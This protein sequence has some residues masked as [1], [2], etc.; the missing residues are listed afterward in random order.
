MVGYAVRS[1]YP[2]LTL[3]DCGESSGGM[4]SF[5]RADLSAANQRPPIAIWTHLSL[6]YAAL[7]PGG[8]L[9]NLDDTSYLDHTLIPAAYHRDLVI[10]LFP[11]H[12]CW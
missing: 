10:S 2:A 3:L 6:Q 7:G 8:N 1:C 11:A 4:G 5:A 12:E 9:G